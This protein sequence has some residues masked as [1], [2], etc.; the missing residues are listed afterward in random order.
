M[1]FPGDGVAQPLAVLMAGNAVQRIGA[2]IEE[3]AFLRV[4]AEAAHAEPL[5][6]FVLHFPIQH[7]THRAGVEI[8]VAHAVP[9][10]GMLERHGRVDAPAGQYLCTGSV[11]NRELDFT[12]A[13]DPGFD[14]NVSLA[15]ADGRGN[16]HTAAAEIIQCNVVLVDHQQRHITVDA[17]VEG[18]VGFLGVDA[19]ILAVVHSDN[20]VVVLCQ[21]RGDVSAEGGVAAVMVNDRLAVQRDI[22]TGVHALKLQP[23][24]LG[25]RVKGGCRELRFVGADAAPVIVA[26]VLTV[27]VVPCVGQ[28][29][30][31]GFAVG[32]GELP[33]FHQLGRASHCALLC[34]FLLRA[35]F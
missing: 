18:E 5:A 28:S 30:G 25:G 34:C 19:V 9:Q 31:G 8:R 10:V 2:A 27:D 16:L 35:I 14:G 7:Q 24:L 17:A 22:R 23:D 4:H 13:L 20:Q 32:A 33:V 26:A 6:D 3:E 21:Q 15:A 12:L 1:H 29:H 11:Q